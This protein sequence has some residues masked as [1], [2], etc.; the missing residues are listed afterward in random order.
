M[1]TE[2]K[3]PGWGRRWG[4]WV[5]LAANLLLYGTGAPLEDLR[6][7]GGRVLSVHCKDARRAPAAV[8]GEA[9]GEE[10]PLGDGEVDIPAYVRTLAEIG[11]RGPL[12]IE[13]ETPEDRAQQKADVA[14]AVRVLGAAVGALK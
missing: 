10:V 12:T 7:V 13:R 4:V 9:W 3:Q 2:D 1:P 11:Y 14:H 6:K 5:S 8:R